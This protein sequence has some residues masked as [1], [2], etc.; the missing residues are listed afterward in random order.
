MLPPRAR[1]GARLRKGLDR[2]PLLHEPRRAIRPR[3]RCLKSIAAS[4][5]VRAGSP[6]SGHRNDR[7]PD[8]RLRVGFVPPTCASTPWPLFSEPILAELA[9]YFALQLHDISTTPKADADT[10]RM[11][12]QLRRIDAGRRDAPT[13]RWRRPIEADGI[14][15]LVDLSGHT[16]GN[17]LRCSHASPRPCR[18][19]GSATS[20]P[21]DSRA[22]TTTS[23]TRASCRRS[24]GARFSEK[25]V[26]L[27]AWAAFVP[28]A[29]LPPVDPLPALA[30]GYLTFGSFNRAE[31]A[32][33]GGRRHCGPGVRALPTRAWCWAACRRKASR[34]RSRRFAARGRLRATASRSTHE[35][36][37]R[38][39]LTLHGLVDIVL[40]RFHMPAATRRHTPL[41][42]RPGADAGGSRR[43]RRGRARRS[44]CMRDC[45]GSS[46]TTRRSS[47][48]RCCMGH[49]PRTA[50]D[51]PAKTASAMLR[52]ADGRPAVVAARARTRAAHDVAALVRGLPADRFAGRARQQKA[53][54]RWRAPRLAK[55]AAT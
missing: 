15:V 42:G 5:R 1:A 32:R 49:R 8:R 45:P 14:D 53:R 4:E 25:V 28:A 36:W 16:A 17:R 46:R 27:P 10:M 2:S 22:W 37:H 11:R 13:R 51:R 7:D 41:H 43:R 6:S 54:R 48:A 21:P 50:G 35:R 9:R 34:T 26:L 20:A 40:D 44:C 23:P 55:P 29:D 19:A 33:S 31:Q 39:Y 18:R 47:S 30:N 38:E 24:G 3:T 12:A 52:L